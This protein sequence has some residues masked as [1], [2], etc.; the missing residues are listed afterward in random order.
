M[1][2]LGEWTCEYG[3]LLMGSPDSAISIV[4]VDGLLNLPDVRSADLT[5]VQ[6]N[7]LWPGDDYLGGRTVTVTL[8]VYGRDAEEFSAALNAV[9]AAFRVGPAES[10]FRFRFPGVAGGG[11]AYVMARTR[12]RSAPL[13]LDFAYH[14]CNIVVEL[15]A[16][17]P[18]IRADQPRTVTVGAERAY[19]TALGSEPARPVIS[20]TNVKN[21]M[22]GDEA[23]GFQFGLTFTGSCTVDSAAQTVT[24]SSGTD[25]TTLVKTG[26]IWPEYAAGEHR[27]TL[28]TDSTTGPTSAA[29]TWRETWV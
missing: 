21:P 28:T 14:V 4:Q 12:K 23:T 29:I 17:A 6:R 1:A 8:E 25:I 3:G 13:N 2:E 16:T 22:L 19:F 15:F 18:E 11:T 7:G 10:R 9:Q 20:L 5:L 24:T 26:S 27:V